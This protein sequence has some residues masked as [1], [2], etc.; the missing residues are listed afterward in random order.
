MGC[1]KKWHGTAKWMSIKR[2]NSP[3]V[4]VQAVYQL[5]EC[6][7]NKEK[8]FSVQ[9]PSTYHS[10]S[11]GCF[12]VFLPPFYFPS[13]CLHLFSWMY[14]PSSFPA[15]LSVC[16]ASLCWPEAMPHT[17]SPLVRVQ[18]CLA[19][20]VSVCVRV[21]VCAAKITGVCLS[22]RKK[23]D[24]MWIFICIFISLHMFL[25]L[26]ECLNIFLCVHL[27]TRMCVCVCVP[28]LHCLAAINKIKQRK[29]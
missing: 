10:V 24:G 29:S 15:K 5:H 1:Q 19:A 6:W 2:V 25:R 27:G 16:V 20:S 12:A 28:G 26:G 18:V 7:T 3:V 14:L 9:P 11:L 21:C 23:E 22:G 8:A 4:E 17:V 13:L